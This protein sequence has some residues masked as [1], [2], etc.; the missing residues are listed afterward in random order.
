[1]ATP[2]PAAHHRTIKPL[3]RF[4]DQ[5]RRTGTVTDRELVTPSMWR[6]R[7]AA[8]EPLPA[9]YTPGQHIR[10]QINDPL[11]LYG[12]FRPSDTLRTYTIWEYDPAGDAI[13]LRIH[14]YDGDGIGIRWVESATV[15]EPVTFWGPMGEFATRPGPRHLFVGDET[16]TA[17][18][19]PMIAG[20]DPAAS[21][22]G[23]LESESPEDDLPLPGPHQL[24]RVHRRGAPAVASPTLVTALAQQDLPDQPAVAYL[25]GEARTCQLLLQA[26]VRD[27]GWPR[28]AV[29]VKP[30][31]AA[32]KRGLH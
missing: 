22:T 9:E 13:E 20:L 5:H 14:R 27:R 6:I 4:F 17:A 16:A 21:V 1:M 19:G 2:Q 30:F 15:G 29:V 11:S 12:I 26:L 8:D 28:S 7:V 31:W 3:A 10:L 25:A 18:F 24:R 23:I 32:G